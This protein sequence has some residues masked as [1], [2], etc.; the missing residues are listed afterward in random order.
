MIKLLSPIS[1]SLSP[2]PLWIAV[3]SDIVLSFPIM[4]N[5]V[6]LASLLSG[7]VPITQLGL[8]RFL[9]PILAGPR[10]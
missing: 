10:I 7:S 3:N 8:I 9:S 5:P 6:G 1:V 2:V 4:I